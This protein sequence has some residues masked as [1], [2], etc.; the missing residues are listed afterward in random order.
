MSL[1]TRIA[2]VA[3]V[4]V[5]LA[6]LAA[7]VGLYAAVSSDLRGEV[8]SSLR[9]RARGIAAHVPAGA[10]GANPRAHGRRGG[11]GFP[12]T[13]G[14]AAGPHGFPGHVEPA[15]FGAAS[16][17]VQFISPHG[18]VI[19]PGGQGAASHRIALS[20]RDRA[21]AAS[22]AGSG[23]TNRTV[24]GTELRVLTQ[25][26]GARGAVIVAQPLTEVDHELSRLLLI[27]AAIGGAGVVLAALLGALVARTALAPVARFT[28]RT[29]T[30]TGD[31]D[32]SRRLEVRGRD[33][34]ARLAESFNTTLDALERSVQAQRHLVADASHELR[35]PIASLRANVQV[36]ADAERLPA[37]EQEGLR[38][39]IVAELDELTALVGDVVELARSAEPERMAADVRLDELVRAAVTSARR[40]GAGAGE[41]AQAGELRFALELEPTLVRG[42]AERIARAV[43]NLVDNARKW[44]PPGG[45]VEVALRDGVLSVRDHGPGFQE[46]DLRSV[47]DRFYRAREARKLPG[48]GLGLAIVRH[49]AEAHGGFATAA[50]APGGGALLRVS[51]GAPIRL[52]SEEHGVPEAGEGIAGP[53]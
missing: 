11:G 36:L 46:E 2:A 30:L 41:R 53:G 37:H 39:D 45:E 47:F 17:Y 26:A 14:A 3:G 44:S 52:E 43:S 15:P 10:P 32:L 8:D 33:E 9:A 22:G 24:G 4:S 31:L 28:R 29:E 7:A 5:A 48:S 16:G 27:L 50:N 12:G 35:T 42:H 23:F 19:V 40:R 20:A 6:V 38:A 25:G 51:F 13:G 21:I 1:R 18:E 49:A 34:L